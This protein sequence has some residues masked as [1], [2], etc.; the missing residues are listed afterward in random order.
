[1]HSFKRLVE[2]LRFD[3]P[4]F[5]GTLGVASALFHLILCLMERLT[6]DIKCEEY[7]R[8][9]ISFFVAGFVSSLILTIGLLPGEL[10]LLKLFFY[11]L[12][13]RC[14]CNTLLETGFV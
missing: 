1:M 7:Q 6:K 8:K 13:Y 11:P 4:R 2:V 5:G 3:I 14:L 12:A 9:C 10:S